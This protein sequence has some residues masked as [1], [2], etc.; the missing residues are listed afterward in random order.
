[1]L[2]AL[3]THFVRV[4]YGGVV[5]VEPTLVRLDVAELE[6]RGGDGE[7]EEGE[8]V[9]DDGGQADHDSLCCD[10]EEIR[11]W[12]VC[13]TISRQLIA[14]KSPNLLPSSS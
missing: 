9:V 4:T 2:T 12:A 13:G 11:H 5:T 6:D 3:D 1:M 7:D 10:W 14:R 8:G